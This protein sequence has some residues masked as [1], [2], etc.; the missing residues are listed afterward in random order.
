MQYEERPLTVEMSQEIVNRWHNFPFV[1]GDLGMGGG[2]T[3]IGIRSIALMDPNAFILVVTVKAQIDDQHWENSV[4]A[5]NQAMHTDLDVLAI[6]YEKLYHTIPL[7][8]RKRNGM[9]KRFRQQLQNNGF[10]EQDIEDAVTEFQESIANKRETILY[11][12]DEIIQK[13]NHAKFDEHRPIYIILD[14]CQKIKNTKSNAFKVVHKLQPNVKRILG[15]S[16]TPIGNHAIDIAAYFELNNFIQSEREFINTFSNKGCDQHHNMIEVR[17]HDPQNPKKKIINWNETFKHAD[18]LQNTYHNFTVSKHIKNV[19]PDRIF[20]DVDNILT[21]TEYDQY[22]QIVDA[23]QQGEFDS[24]PQFR[25]YLMQFLGVLPSKINMLLALLRHPA[26]PQTPTL[27]FYTYQH[28]F[29]T[30]KPILENAGYHVYQKNGNN[31][32]KDNINF[33][34]LS[35]SKDIILAQYQAGGTGLN[36]PNARTSILYEVH[37]SY[38]Q[39]KQALGRN[40]RA[41]EKESVVQLRLINYLPGQHKQKIASMESDI[42]HRVLDEAVSFNAD[43]ENQIIQ[44]T[45][46][47]IKT[48]QKGMLKK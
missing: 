18:W 17:M 42:Y 40:R 9:L 48:H 13:L 37:T 26:R 24:N 7:S 4:N 44:H 27:I 29:D 5:F 11:P 8:D 41:Y 15:L 20:N 22:C 6:N 36:I 33:R 46:K 39:Y 10:D 32:K 31:R 34:E 3:F 25:A 35:D 1:L 19:L 2:K 43:I 12:K 23:Y 14:E 28:T 38:I 21:P 30:L 16:A 47:L 45:E